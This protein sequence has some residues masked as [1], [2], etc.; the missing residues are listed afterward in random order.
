MNTDRKPVLATGA[1]DAPSYPEQ[2]LTG[3]ILECAFAVHN[4]LG[5]GF[6]ECV[7]SNAL[8]IELRNK[9][10]KCIQEAPLKVNYKGAIV[11]DYAADMVVDDAVLIEL[12][13]CAVLDPNHRAQ[14]INYL[15]AS[16]IRVG[17][18]INF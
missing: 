5:A 6:L 11:G 8:A 10:L 16:G 17:L 7:Y 18:L 13:A 2:E 12:K 4:T 15:R 14:I 1:Q 3:K 9:S